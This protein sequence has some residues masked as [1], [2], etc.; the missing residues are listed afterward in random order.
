MISFGIRRNTTSGK[1]DFLLCL[2][3]RLNPILDPFPVIRYVDPE[4]SLVL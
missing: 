1:E 4:R 3:T 2:D